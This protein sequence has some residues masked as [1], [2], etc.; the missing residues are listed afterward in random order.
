MIKKITRKVINTFKKKP[1]Q[2]LL[3]DEFWVQKVKT[4]TIVDRVPFFE[5]I[6]KDKNVLHLGCNDWPIFNPTYNLH[7]KLS[8]QAKSI[9]GFDVDL[10]GIENLKK[11]VNQNYYSEFNQLEGN[12]YDVCFVPETIEHVDDVRTFLEGLSTVNSEVFY[13]TAPNCFAKKHIERNFYGNNEFIEVVHPDHNCWY[14]PFTLKNQIE[15]YSNLKV[16]K[17]FL[18]DGDTMVCCQASKK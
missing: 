11:Y 4:E 8:K 10:E 16:D 17:V 12:V 2:Y 7:I 6:A 15:K 14:S 5:N 1:E 18:L 9:H 3:H 13:I